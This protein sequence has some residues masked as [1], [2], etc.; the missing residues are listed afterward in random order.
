[1]VGL[2]IHIYVCPNVMVFLTVLSPLIMMLGHILSVANSVYYFICTKTYS[3][4]YTSLKTSLQPY[5]S[6]RNI[7]FKTKYVFL[8]FHAVQFSVRFCWSETTAKTRL[9]VTLRPP[10]TFPTISSSL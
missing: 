6:M 1:M 4:Y 8:K 2:Y 9:A 10:P 3:A 5:W 7:W